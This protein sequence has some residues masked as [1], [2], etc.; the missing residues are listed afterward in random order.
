MWTF[1]KQK[2]FIQ[3]RDVRPGSVTE[4]CSPGA[5]VQLQFPDVHSSLAGVTIIRILQLVSQQI[6]RGPT[7]VL[8]NFTDKPVPSGISRSSLRPHAGSPH[9]VCTQVMDSAA[10]AQAKNLQLIS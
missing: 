7:V 1:L 6:Y 4:I 2:G 8:S 9:L 10:D 3:L 5:S